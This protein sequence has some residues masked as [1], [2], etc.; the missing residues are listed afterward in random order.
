M[1]CIQD[2]F[3]YLPVYFECHNILE[4]ISLHNMGLI[5]TDYLLKTLSLHVPTGYKNVS[6]DVIFD[7]FAVTFETFLDT[8]KYLNRA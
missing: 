8:F 7:T 3:S 4:S 6:F 2:Y 1:Q 5:G